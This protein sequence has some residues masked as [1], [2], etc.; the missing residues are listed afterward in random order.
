MSSPGVKMITREE[1]GQSILITLQDA[2][3]SQ[4]NGETCATI[5]RLL[6]DLGIA[7]VG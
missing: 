7:R 2:K 6:D 1:G 4:D 5:Q 3:D